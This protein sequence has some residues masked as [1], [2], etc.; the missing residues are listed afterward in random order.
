V[1][2]DDTTRLL[3]GDF[4]EASWQRGVAALR[5][6]AWSI[7]LRPLWSFPAPENGACVVFLLQPRS[8]ADARKLGSGLL[9]QTMARGMSF[10]LVLRGC[11]RRRIPCQRWIGNLIALP[12][13][14]KPGENGNTLFVDAQFSPF[15]I[16]GHFFLLAEDHPSSLQSIFQRYARME[17][18]RTAPLNTRAKVG[19]QTRAP[20]LHKADFP[21]QARLMI[22]NS[23]NMDKQGFPS[24]VNAFKAVAAFRIH[25]FYK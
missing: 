2:E 1:S 22:S 12:F 3:A 24:R 5:V 9:K 8:A 11:F 17:G 6:P 21:M 14:G 25:E 13:Q 19:R 23:F 16:C 4:D 18:I 10:T 20:H 15:S 7:F